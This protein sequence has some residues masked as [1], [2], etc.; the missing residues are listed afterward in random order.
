MWLGS[1]VRFNKIWL[2]L[3]YDPNNHLGPAWIGVF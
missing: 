2:D 3:N 1:K